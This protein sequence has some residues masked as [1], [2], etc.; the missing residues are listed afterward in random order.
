MNT[1]VR[2]ELLKVRTTRT[3]RG[4]VIAGIGFAAFLGAVTASL[5]G[6]EG[7]APLGSA[8][9]VG[10][11]VGVSTIPAALGLLLGVLLAA[12]EHQHGTVTTTFLVEPRRHRVVAAKGIAA[13]VA[14]TAVAGAMVLAAVAGAAP[15]VLAE[16]A[17]VGVDAAAART[18]AGLVLGSA[19]LAVVGVLLGHLLRSQVAAIVAV[20]LEFTLLEAVADTLAGGG[21]HR[22]L[23]G[24]A[25]ATLAG[26]GDE[27]FWLAATVLTAW[28]V[29]AA[30][31]TVPAV[32]R[33]DVS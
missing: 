31:V 17:D 2:S 28:A 1:L 21:L 20:V 7:N 6:K 4:L 32:V 33:R 16:G 19:L 9:M 30:A 23:P 5:A 26:G 18:V 25:A 8:D 15:R 13:A 22:W 14:A 29:V 12:G 10:N 24:G 27:P 3:T 11:V